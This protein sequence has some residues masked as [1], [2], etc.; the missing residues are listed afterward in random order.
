LISRSS[1]REIH[2]ESPLHILKRRYV[3]RK[4]AGFICIATKKSISCVN[5]ALNCSLICCTRIQTFLF[6]DNIE[7]SPV[8]F[9]KAVNGIL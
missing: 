7:F 1:G 9:C 6:V 8:F 2:G 4:G 5:F 3:V